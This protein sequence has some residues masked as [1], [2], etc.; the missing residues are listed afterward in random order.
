MA[1][2]LVIADDFT[3]ALDTGVQFTT[4][5]AS[6]RVVTDRDFDFSMLDSSVQVLVMDSETRHLD[7]DT[8]YSNIR[9]IADRAFRSGIRHI[10]KKTDSALRGNLGAELAALLDASGE[11]IL[12]FIPAFPKMNRI[13]R[14]GI[15]Y[16]DGTIVSDSV[17]GKDPFEP[18]CSGNI[19]EL[20]RKDRLVRTANTN[21][22]EGER[23]INDRSEPEILIWD[24]ETDEDLENIAEILKNSSKTKIIAG[25]A[26]FAAFLPEIIGFSGTMDNAY[27]MKDSFL[28]ICGTQNPMTIRQMDKAEMEGFKRIR[29]S[30]K[31]K[32]EKGFWDSKEG[33]KKLNDL[34]GIIE[35]EQKLIIDCNDPPG[36]DE[37]RKYK[38]E[39]HIGSEDERIRVSGAC[40]LIL[41]GLSEKDL[42]FIALITGGD[43]LI[44]CMEHLGINELRPIAE[45]AP[46]TVLSGF[47]H[48]GQEQM[49]MSKSGGFG[50][51]RL[52]IFLSELAAGN[53]PVRE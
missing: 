49:I 53:I 8:A 51:E 50:D 17:F 7:A 36:T 5:N 43:T 13:T 38:E 1:E 6:T 29:L 32:F 25:C 20:I 41:E 23:V 44:G 21:V 33:K 11:S 15:H 48:D 4:V 22:A 35:K 28:A 31:E 14:D 26:G 2:L 46:G 34:A 27:C 39:N 19:A 52:L 16:I 18:V 37:A 40:G 42:K 3:G 9:N 47:M 12:S 10:Y 30:P 45:I 24:A